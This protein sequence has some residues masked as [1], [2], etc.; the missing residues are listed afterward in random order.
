MKVF[1]NPSPPLFSLNDYTKHRSEFKVKENVPNETEMSLHLSHV[2]F[3]SIGALCKFIIAYLPLR[4]MRKNSI[5]NSIS[6]KMIN[7]LE[8]ILSSGRIMSY[9]EASNES[10]IKLN[11][12]LSN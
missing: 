6:S 10:V 7:T 4:I 1:S 3:Y 12:V 5:H 2:V 11:R 8:S 9:A